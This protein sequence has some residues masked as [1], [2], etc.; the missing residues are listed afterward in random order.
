MRLGGVA[1][2][3]SHAHPK[4]RSQAC[5]RIEAPMRLR[6]CGC[7]P[8]GLQPPGSAGVAAKGSEPRN[9]GGGLPCAATGGDTTAYFRRK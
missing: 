6:C 2:L 1:Q 8:P 3:N 5:V 9:R 7:T 4:C